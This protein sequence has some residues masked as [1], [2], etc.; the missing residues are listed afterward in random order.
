M[1]PDLTRIGSG[2]FC[3]G[4]FDRRTGEFAG[5]PKV[6]DINDNALGSSNGLKAQSGCEAGGTGYL[7]QATST[8]P[9]AA[10]GCYRLTWTG[11]ADVKVGDVVILT[12]GGGS[13]GNDAGC[14]SQ[15]GKN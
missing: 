5:A 14:R 2:E 4:L 7:A 12:P 3:G 8:W 6:C 15:Y 13:G 9:R 11:G 1:S 10:A